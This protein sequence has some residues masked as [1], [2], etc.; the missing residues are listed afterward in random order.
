MVPRW[1]REI[2][3]Y[4]AYTCTETDVVELIDW[5]V[6]D[7]TL[8]MILER[9]DDFMDLNEYIK[10]TFLNEENARNLFV[11]LYATVVRCHHNG[12]VHRDLKLNN[13]LY[14]PKSGEMKLIDF[15][16]AE[17]IKEGPSANFSGTPLYCP[18]EFHANGR[19][20]GKLLDYWA[21]GVVLYATL[22]GQLPF[23]NGKEIQEFHK[24][25][26]LALIDMDLSLECE[27]VIKNL[28]AN[29]EIRSN[30]QN[31]HDVVF[32]WT[33]VKLTSDMS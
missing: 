14:N 22:K 31:I 23:C 27:L 15:G 20:N 28:L 21:L 8:V 24:E 4:A 18:P 1:C 13:V 30:K 7:D 29:E 33:K 32:A 26:T 6:D 11:Q 25:S 10:S 19:F 2:S 16:S 17:C 3:F 5:V 9:P 12:V